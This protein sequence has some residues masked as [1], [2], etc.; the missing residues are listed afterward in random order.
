MAG[1]KAVVVGAGGIAGAWF[2]PLAKEAVKVTAVVDL[3][4]EQAQKRIEE[5]KL[6]ALATT[7]L[8]EAI[9]KTKPDFVIDLTVPEAHAK[10][11]CRLVADQDPDRIF[12]LLRDH[13][14]AIASPGVRVEIVSL[15]GGRPLLARTDHPATRAF[16][17]ALE[18][19][20]GQAPLFVRE[21][22]SNPVAASFASIVGLPVTVMGFMPPDG[23]FHAPNEWMDLANFEG[24]IRALVRFYEIY[25]APGA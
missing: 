8:R 22:G 1:E 25:A 13:V 6:D 17:R 2:P 9:R 18:E 7:N 5:Y 15:G 23:N 20:F 4:L 16:A 10:V 14:L 3:R 11:T 19:T 24:G 12:A 21:G